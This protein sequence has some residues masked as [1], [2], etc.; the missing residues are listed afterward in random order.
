MILHRTQ[1]EIVAKL[2][3]GAYAK[4]R[5]VPHVKLPILYEE[6]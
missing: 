1:Q 2:F 5:T 6:W 4:G 3:Y